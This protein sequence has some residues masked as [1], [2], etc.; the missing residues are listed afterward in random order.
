MKEWLH[1]R[2]EKKM[3][4]RNVRHFHVVDK[5]EKS[6]VAFAR[7]DIPEGFE[8]QFGEWLDSDGGSRA[9][10]E[11]I[12]E[13]ATTT[14]MTVP[15]EEAEPAIA[16]TMAGPRGSDPELCRS[17][18]SVLSSLSKKWDAEGMLG[19]ST[20]IFHSSVTARFFLIHLSF[21]FPMPFAAPETLYP[22]THHH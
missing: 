13:P 3:V 20:L 12:E 7:W 6:I 22:L 8:A 16:S 5:T 14:A 17:F 1:E 4:D 10:S 19:A 9:V 18:F 11:N 21:L 2:I 15:V